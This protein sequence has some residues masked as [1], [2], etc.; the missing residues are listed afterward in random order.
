MTTISFEAPEVLTPTS[1]D[2]AVAAFGDGRDVVV[3]GGGTILMPQLQGGRLAAPRALLLNRA[4]LD[5]IERQNGTLRIGATVPVSRLEREAPDPLASAARGVADY[6]IRAQA[7]VGGNLCAQPPPS[8]EVP[9]GDLQAPLIALD[10]RVRTAGAGGE[11]VDPVEAFLAG[12]RDGRLVL[13]LEVDEPQG[14]AYA[15]IGRPHAHTYTVLA[16]ACA[17]TAGGVR[18]AVGGIAPHARRAPS[19]EQALAGGADAAAAAQRVLDDV[20][21]QDDALAS[22]WYRGRML[23]TLVQRALTALTNP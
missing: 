9:P 12:P 17:A 10:A 19:V 23:P 21:P 22:A 3:F 13:E 7:T 5:R 6:E 4:G 2:E 11:R 15:T 8:L 14:A 20:E 1:R 18:V 16:V